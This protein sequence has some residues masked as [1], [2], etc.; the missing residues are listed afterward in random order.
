MFY[1]YHRVSTSEQNIERGITGIE[2]F[3]K[4]RGYTLQ[5]IYVDKMSGKSFDRP[6]YIVLKEDVL[7]SGDTL[8]LSELDRLGRSQSDIVDEIAFFKE[9]G[10][11]VMF[12]DI[13]TTTTDFDDSNELSR[14]IMET[15][16]NIL[17]DIYSLNAQ[18]ELERN[19]KRCA[20][21]R[22]A[23]KARG[24]WD[25]YGRPRKMKKEQFAKYYGRVV[26]GEIGSVALMRELDMNRNTFFRYVRE[27][28]ESTKDPQKI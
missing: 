15:V 3:C 23:M 11:R 20:E 10:V 28:K 16:N 26:R 14:I 8:I 22:E 4:D 13:P 12:L 5:K 2:E 6:R 24:D 7:R 25:K 27:Y 17:I 19:R 18:A 9:K 1:G 21:G